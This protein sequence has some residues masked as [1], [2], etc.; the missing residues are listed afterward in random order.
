MADH[1]L[2]LPPPISVYFLICKR[3]VNNV[4]SHFD[5]ELFEMNSRPTSWKPLTYGDVKRL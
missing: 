1:N 4:V 3:A 2:I 5:Y